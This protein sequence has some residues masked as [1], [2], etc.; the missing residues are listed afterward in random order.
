MRPDASPDKVQRIVTSAAHLHF[1]QD[2]RFNSQPLNAQW[3]PRPTIG[4]RAWPSV[5][6]VTGDQDPDVLTLR[7]IALLLWLNT[8]VGSAV[9]WLWSSRQQTGRGIMTREVIKTL[10]VLDVRTLTKDQLIACGGIFHRLK[11]EAL[12]PLHELPQDTTRHTLDRALLSEVL[13]WPPLWF[14][15]H[16][17]MDILRQKLAAEPSI[18]GHRNH[19]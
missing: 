3:T 9:R 19:R 10:P 4:G 17:P 18:H 15:E 6:M 14:A 11:T 2:W 1:N 16:G 5:T 7:A 12:H 8:T 13:G